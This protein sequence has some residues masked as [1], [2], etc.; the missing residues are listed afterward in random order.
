MPTT[1]ALNGTTA[2][3]TADIFRFF[4][5]PQEIK[6]K[7]YVAIL[8][9][10]RFDHL[11]E[12]TTDIEHLR[13]FSVGIKIPSTRLISTRFDNELSFVHTSAIHPTRF[14]EHIGLELEIENQLPDITVYETLPWEGSA[15]FGGIPQRYKNVVKSLDLRLILD[16]HAQHLGTSAEDTKV[17]VDWMISLV[18]WLWDLVANAPALEDLSLCLTVDT[19]ADLEALAAQMDVLK[20]FPAMKKVE[21]YWEFRHGTR[22]WLQCSHSFDRFPQ[23]NLLAIKNENGEWDDQEVWDHGGSWGDSRGSASAVDVVGDWMDDYPV[24]P[25]AW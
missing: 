2:R 25:I 15:K 18:D 8:S 10:Q 14:P 21:M 5:L 16:P 11:E 19:T 24:A 23:Y 3:P 9:R 20:K 4:D 7:I 1:N 12:I 17:R 22:I 13:R 6:D